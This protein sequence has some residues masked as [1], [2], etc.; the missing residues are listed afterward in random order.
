MQRERSRS[1]AYLALFATLVLALTLSIAMCGEEAPAAPPVVPPVAEDPEVVEPEVAPE[2]PRATWTEDT[3]ELTSTA[4]GPYAVGVPSTFEVRL[5]PRGEYHVNTNYPWSVTVTPPAAVLVPTATFD[6]TTAAEM[7]ETIARFVVP[8][9]PT[10]AGTHTVTAAV[11][12]GIC[13]EEACIFQ[14][15]SVLVTVVAADG[16]AADGLVPGALPLVLPPGTVVPAAPP[17]SGP[18]T[19][20]GATSAVTPPIPAAAEAGGR[21]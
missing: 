5:T 16:V 14:M 9:T 13:R 6:S 10:A 12:F 20:P 19:P 2:E 17:G 21:S 4:T 18:A 11:D 3:Y 7:T 15:H 8:F 1:L